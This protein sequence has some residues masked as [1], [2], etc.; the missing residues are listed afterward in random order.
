MTNAQIETRGTRLRRSL[1]TALI[2]CA[3]AYVGVLVVLLAFENAMIFVPSR[4]PEGNWDPPGIV[5]EDAWFHAADGTRLHGWFIPHEKPKAFLLFAHGNAGNL[6]HRTPI[7]GQLHHHASAAVMIFDYRGYGRSEGSP[8]EAGI[9]A[10]AQAAR[11]WLAKRAGIQEQDIVLYGESL[12][13]GVMVDLASRS[14]AKALIL[15]STFSSLP[16]V[17]SRA[18]PWIP[19]RTL[20]R[21]RLDSASKIN[22]FHGPLLQFH[23]NAD[24]IIPLEIG[25]KLFQ[26]ANQPKRFV[27]LVGHDHN[28]PPPYELFEE[29]RQFLDSLSQPNAPSL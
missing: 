29:I 20:M 25:Q 4:H 19:V 10:D 12:G 21:T 11:A 23:G 15:E 24:S 28:D 16:D 27:T 22:Q 14:P 8:N 1:K 9:L 7:V 2:A 3:I 18:F 5:F 13:G 17:A 6:T 26:H